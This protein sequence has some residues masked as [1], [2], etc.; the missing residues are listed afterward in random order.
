MPSKLTKTTTKP[1]QTTKLKQTTKPT[2][3]KNS[4]N[5]SKRSGDK[6][7]FSGVKTK[8]NSTKSKNELVNY[9]LELLII[10]KVYHWKTKS[11]A[12]HK[13]TDE[14]YERLN[15]HI[16]TFVEVMLGKGGTR[17]DMKGRKI[18]ITD[19]S[20]KPEIRKIIYQ[21]RILLEDKMNEYIK[22]KGN[23][24]LYNIRDEILGNINQFLY[25]IT[26]E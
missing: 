18:V 8:E 9:F 2:V 13:A 26:F 6:E 21:Y 4:M 11:Y 14:L 1:K 7:L 24:D 25:L 22:E 5:L 12:V 10:I 19:P 3:K 20:T 16:D 15:E 23:T 17:L